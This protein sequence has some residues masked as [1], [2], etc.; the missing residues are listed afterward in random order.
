MGKEDNLEK[1]RYKVI[2]PFLE[3][4]KSLKD[5]SDEEDVS[6][7]TLKRWVSYYK[8]NG[9]SGLKKTT[10]KDKNTYRSVDK[11]TI[12]YVEKVYRENPDIKIQDLH[13]K[14]INFIKK[15][16]GEK[17]SYDT[18][19]R[20]VNNLDPFVKK[21][22]D[23]YSLKSKESNEI[24]EFATGVLNVSVLDEFVDEMK[25]PYLSIVYDTYSKAVCSCY[26]SF[27]PPNLDDALQ[28]FRAAILEDDQNSFNIYGKPKEYVIND[29]RV[30]E[31][32]RLEEIKTELDME[33]NF[34]SGENKMSEFYENLNEVYLLDMIETE[35]IEV[36]YRLLK[37]RI[38]DY[39]ESVHNFRTKD[40]W[41]GGL[42]ELRVV[43]NKDILDILLSR[44]KSERK[45]QNYGV[46]FQNLFYTNSSLEKHIGENVE[47]LYN[48]FDVSSIKIY[49]NGKYLSS[50]YCK[51]LMG[52]HISLYELMC[53]KRYINIK[54]YDKTFNLSI[55]LKEVMDTISE[56]YP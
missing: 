19:Y 25:N 47:V 14:V 4:R 54:Y 17:I 23:P 27:E 43:P 44:L 6:Y 2:K 31:K 21:Y 33:I 29:I 16:G 9:L 18:V 12:K 42:K 5:I 34:S 15:M 22:A 41:L 52:K 3:N 32:K 11:K 8:K 1:K 10:R 28:L 38:E 46:R 49:R 36:D 13:D 53:I 56:R 30:Q 37:V 39:I 35:R 50:A 55:Y 40:K 51:E 20:I 24:F 45:I 48:I 26:I 7:S